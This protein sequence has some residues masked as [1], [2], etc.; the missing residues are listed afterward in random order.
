MTWRCSCGEEAP[1]DSFVRAD[2]RAQ[3]VDIDEFLGRVRD[4][5][6]A[7]TEQQWRSP[8]AEQ[9]NVGRIGDRCYLEAIDRMEVLSRNVRSELIL[10]A[11]LGPALH[12]RANGRIVAD[13]SEHDFGLRLRGDDVRLGPATNRPNV[14]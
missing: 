4:V 1:H 13:Q 12:H 10:G 6:R 8:S 9:W 5:N 2:G 3:L 7:R 11:T 14:E